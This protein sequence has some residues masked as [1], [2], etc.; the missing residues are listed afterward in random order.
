[1]NVG[2]TVLLTPGEWTC[3]V[4]RRGHGPVPVR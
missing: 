3:S 4:D 1:M 2:M